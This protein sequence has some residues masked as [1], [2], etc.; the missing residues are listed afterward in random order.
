MTKHVNKF[1]TPLQQL[2]AAGAPLSD[3]DAIHAF[4]ESVPSKYPTFVNSLKRQ[5]TLTLLFFIS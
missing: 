4:N 1:C 3:E 5:P 2:A